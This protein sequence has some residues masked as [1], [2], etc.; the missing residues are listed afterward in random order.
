L[1]SDQLSVDPLTGI[2]LLRFVY[3]DGAPLRALSYADFHDAE[4]LA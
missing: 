4:T 3:F 2:A 1:A